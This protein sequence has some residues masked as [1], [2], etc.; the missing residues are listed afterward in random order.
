MKFINLCSTH[1][2]TLLRGTRHAVELPKNCIYGKDAAG[3]YYILDTRP[4]KTDDGTLW[5]E[6][7]RFQHSRWQRGM[8]S[9]ESVSKIYAIILKNKWYGLKLENCLHMH[10]VVMS[11]TKTPGSRHTK[12]LALKDVSR[13]RNLYGTYSN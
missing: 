8:E 11:R 12:S 1:G 2:Q 13:Q 3:L 9:G 10:G 7:Y 6:M 5:L 4:Y